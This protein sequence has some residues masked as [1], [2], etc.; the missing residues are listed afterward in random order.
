MKK[1]F[2]HIMALWALI[3]FGSTICLVALYCFLTSWQKEPGKTESFRLLSIGWI[4][5]FLFLSGC[6]FKIK[7]RENFEKGK[8]YVV[9]CNHN[10]FL[11]VPVL[12]PFVP[13]PNKT[14][15]KAEMSKI[16]IFG[17][18]YK[19]GSILVDRKNKESR[20]QSFLQMIKVLENGMHMCIYPEG[21]RNKTDQ[22]LKEFHDGAFR[23][24]VDTNKAVI[25]AVIFNTKKIMPPEEK[26][27]FKPKKIE[28]HFLPPVFPEPGNSFE[29]LKSKV[30]QIM[31]NH[32]LNYSKKL[33]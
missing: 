5:F 27:Y 24:A 2:Y 13:G 16:P 8:V 30:H 1:I 11:D 4:R 14:I 15:A 3:V 28:L 29:E 20:R 32:Y 25:P 19:R 31:A 10:S 21:T 18:V 9:T 26:F 23:L 6:P 7:G 17:I 12:T 33:K 22:P